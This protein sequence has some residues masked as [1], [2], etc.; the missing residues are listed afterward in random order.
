L[1]FLLIFQSQTAVVST[2]KASEAPAMFKES[3]L[4]NQQLFKIWNL[5]EGV[6]DDDGKGKGFLKKNEWI[7]ALHMIKKTQLGN[8][9]P[10]FLPVELTQF[11]EGY[12][13][14]ALGQSMGFD[15][16]TFGS[17]TM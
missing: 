12:E 7:I 9:I 11:L 2:L 1:A 15:S 10:D 8:P 6:K 13:Q 14:V 17:N 4:N 3:K 16:N 5:C